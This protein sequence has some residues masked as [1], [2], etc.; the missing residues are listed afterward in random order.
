MDENDI[1]K[2]I[3]ENI[4]TGD[5]KHAGF[6]NGEESFKL[7]KDGEDK[8]RYMIGTDPESAMTILSIP[9]NHD[10]TDKFYKTIE[11]IHEC[12]KEA[13]TK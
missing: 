9:Y 2:A 12:R 5:M 4:R 13:E 1:D 10:E 7:T 6:K 3:E 8:A 11:L